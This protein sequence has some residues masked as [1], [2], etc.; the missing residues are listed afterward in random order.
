MKNEAKKYENE[1]ICW[2]NLST[3]TCRCISAFE[4]K[5]FKSIE[6]YSDFAYEEYSIYEIDDTRYFQIEKVS[7]VIRHR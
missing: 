1:N 5:D 3:F 7:S 6:S 4:F 2:N